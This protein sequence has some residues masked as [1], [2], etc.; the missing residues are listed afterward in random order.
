MIKILLLLVILLPLLGG[1]ILPLLR[2]KEKKRLHIYVLAVLIAEA[3]PSRPPLGGY[4]RG[5]HSAD[6]SDTS[7][8]RV[9]DLKLRVPF[10]AVMEQWTCFLPQAAVSSENTALICTCC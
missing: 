6:E 4:C 8:S 7:M 5:S 1:A 2:L 9:F 10:S 3:H